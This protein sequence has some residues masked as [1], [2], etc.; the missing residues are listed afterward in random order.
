VLRKAAA[1]APD[2]GAQPLKIALHALCSAAVL[3]SQL[4]P[5]QLA[6]VFS[7]E[8]KTPAALAPRV[9][10]DLADIFW[11]LGLQLDANA[12]AAV[13]A[14]DETMPDA[15]ADA[16]PASAVVAPPFDA[17]ACKGRLLKLIAELISASVRAHYTYYTRV[18][19]HTSLA[20]RTLDKKTSPP[21][22]PSRPPRVKPYRPETHRH[23]HNGKN[24]IRSR[25]F[26]PQP[27]SAKLLA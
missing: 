6:E 24:N 12:K 23:R 15:D 2:G 25:M 19:Q 10:S 26:P 8:A 3:T 14:A 22:R 13:P 5:S 9:A 16:A 18:P 11:F 1:A 17:D 7:D 21:I 4:S 27:H 20:R